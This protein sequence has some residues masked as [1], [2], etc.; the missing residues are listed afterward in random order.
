MRTDY[1]SHIFHFCKT[2]CDFKILNFYFKEFSPASHPPPPPC[3][4]EP[5]LRENKYLDSGGG[6]VKM[7]PNPPKD[8]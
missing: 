3:G 7:S 5:G 4:A 6:I 2:T 8:K 1:K